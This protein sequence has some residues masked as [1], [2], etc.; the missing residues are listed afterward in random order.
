[1][2]VMFVKG[3]GHCICN[4]CFYGFNHLSAEDFEIYEFE[5]MTLKAGDVV[6]PELVSSHFRACDRLF[7]KHFNL[8]AKCLD[9]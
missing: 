7:R 8:D 1:M 9:E 2:W 4:E 3:H 6:T 5:G